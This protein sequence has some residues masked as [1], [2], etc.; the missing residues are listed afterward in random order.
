MIIDDCLQFA[1]ESEQEV[2]GL[3]L[4]NRILVRCRNVH[5]EPDKNF[6]IHADDWKIAEAVG[7]ITAVF[8]S[9]PGDRLVLSANDRKMQ[10]KM[11]LDWWLASG[12]RLR[13]FKPVPHLLGRHFE[14]GV[15]DCHTLSKDVYHLCGIDLPEFNSVNEQGWWL[16]NENLYLKNLPLNGFYEIE[17]SQLEPFDIILRTPFHG[18]NPSHVMVYLGDNRVIHHDCAGNLSRREPLRPAHWRT[19]HSLWRHKQCSDLNLAGIYEDILA[20]SI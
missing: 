7:N 15:T 18:G 11:G 14:Y 4:D 17:K 3:I 6:R 1:T 9:H 16:K 2:C 8:H 20:M 10:L 5:N 13:I 19:T 12:N